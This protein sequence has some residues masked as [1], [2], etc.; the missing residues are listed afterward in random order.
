[1]NNLYEPKVYQQC[2]DP[3]YCCGWDMAYRVRCSYCQEQWPCE[4]YIK[5]HKPSEIEKERRY[6]DRISF[7]GDE[8]MVEYLAQE[9]AEGRK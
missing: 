8:S 1:M 5:N 7:G 6:Y 9:R 3:D 2:S 4:D